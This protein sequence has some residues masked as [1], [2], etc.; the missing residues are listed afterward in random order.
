MLEY[1][2]IEEAAMRL[3]VIGLAGFFAFLGVYAFIKYTAAA[4]PVFVPE[5]ARSVAILVMLTGVAPFLASLGVARITGGALPVRLIVGAAAGAALC[6]AGYALFFKLV[7]EGA[8][9]GANIVDIA[10]R[11]LGWGAIEGVLAMLT[12]VAKR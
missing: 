11:G 10:R 1:R 7:V 5:Y 12:I 3:S 6:V 8:A 2:R 4:P 9:P